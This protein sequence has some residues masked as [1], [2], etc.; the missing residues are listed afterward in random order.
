MLKCE[1]TE[2]LFNI[3]DGCRFKEFSINKNGCCDKAVKADERQR[4]LA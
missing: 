1:A 4:K 3:N 2:C